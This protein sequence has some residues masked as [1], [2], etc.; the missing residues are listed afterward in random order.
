MGDM[1]D[2]TDLIRIKIK[3]LHSTTQNISVER[4][5]ISMLLVD[6]VNVTDPS[7]RRLR[8]ERVVESGSLLCN[9]GSSLL[10]LARPCHLKN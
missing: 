6:Q 1:D 10:A 3:I 5:N 7:A 2:F 9:L 4:T 8:Q